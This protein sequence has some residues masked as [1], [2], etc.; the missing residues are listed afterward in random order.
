M[1]KSEIRNGI[2]E[3][4]FSTAGVSAENWDEL[5]LFLC[6][7]FSCTYKDFES[8]EGGSNFEN[9]ADLFFIDHGIS[10]HFI[11]SHFNRISKTGYLPYFKSLEVV[12]T[13]Y[14]NL[15]V[16]E[17][18]SKENFLDQA[19]AY[20]RKNHSQLIESGKSKD[21][22]P[23]R[24]FQENYPKEIT[25]S[26][27][28]HNFRV[29]FLAYKIRFTESLKSISKKPL[30]DALVVFHKT[31]L[32]VLFR[33]SNNILSGHETIRSWSLKVLEANALL[34]FPQRDA[35]ISIIREAAK[36]S[37]E[38][39]TFSI[40]AKINDTLSNR[41]DFSDFFIRLSRLHDW[42]ANSR[43][44]YESQ[45]SEMVIKLLAVSE[46]EFRISGETCEIR[47][48]GKQT[49]LKVINGIKIIHLLLS[50]PGK[51]F[52]LPEISGHVNGQYIELENI[53]KWIE[54]KV[55]NSKEVQNLLQNDEL[56]SEI[57]A[58][59]N[60]RRKLAEEHENLRNTLSKALNQA[61]N[62]IRSENEELA[63]HLKE[64]IKKGHVFSY[65]P[66]SNKK[67]LLK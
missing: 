61:I 5:F 33:D 67:F 63:D 32:A 54:I 60:T 18:T 40:L 59:M 20:L 58:L 16:D 6:E 64:Y 9:Y 46:N 48:A 57:R 38:F 55:V 1:G 49:S 62:K 29:N 51:A 66:P 34:G 50:N 35:E 44:D 41:D 2:F 39:D 30:T 37:D 47:Y 28:G 43:F 45:S 25:S 13:I 10:W 23:L 65:N 17:F 52:E 42:C 31:E 15:G 56:S 27:D 19:I 12:L 21:N 36:K 24:Y 8:D 22:F 7:Y 4:Y 14:N 3:R 53:P 11:A 26:I